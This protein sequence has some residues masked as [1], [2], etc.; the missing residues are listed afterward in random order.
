MKLLEQLLTCA[1]LVILWLALMCI[2]VAAAK[3]I[4]RPHDLEK[5]ISVLENEVITLRAENRNLKRLLE[6]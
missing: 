4:A 3:Y 1:L 5:R 2:G 6:E